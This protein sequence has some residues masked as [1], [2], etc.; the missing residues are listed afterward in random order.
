MR[1]IET[2]ICYLSSKLI[3]VKVHRG[4]FPNGNDRYFIEYFDG[5]I[6]PITNEEF[7]SIKEI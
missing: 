5:D 3:Y 6:Q 7:E 2:F 4:R 1:I